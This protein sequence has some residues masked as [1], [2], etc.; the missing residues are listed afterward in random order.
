MNLSSNKKESTYMPEVFN[1]EVYIFIFRYT[2][3]QLLRKHFNNRV[4][5]F[6]P[7]SGI[8]KNV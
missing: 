7:V 1:V 8:Y 6:C 5:K 2:Y 3:L 4:L